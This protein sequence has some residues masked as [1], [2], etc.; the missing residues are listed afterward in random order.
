MAYPP[1]RNCKFR[2][3][4]SSQ[5]LISTSTSTLKALESQNIQEISHLSVAMPF[6]AYVISVRDQSAINCPNDIVRWQL[7]K[8]GQP[9]QLAFCSRLCDPWRRRS[10]VESYSD[11]RCQQCRWLEYRQPS[12][13][14]TIYPQAYD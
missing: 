7:S 4:R 5:I 11:G 10:V 3:S 13:T 9:S 14:T 8:G 12:H 2:T 1:S 6:Y